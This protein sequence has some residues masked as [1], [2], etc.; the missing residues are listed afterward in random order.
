MSSVIMAQLLFLGSENP[1]K[2]ISMYINSPGGS[3]TAGL[4]I[5][6]TMQVRAR[7]RH[8]ERDPTTQSPHP[9]PTCHPPR[10]HAPPLPHVSPAAHLH[11]HSYT[12]NHRHH[13]QYHLYPSSSP[14]I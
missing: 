6:D 9:T 8:K 2:P 1:E 14:S 12:P 13:P 7:A 4:G 5:Y 11:I 3:V 10:H